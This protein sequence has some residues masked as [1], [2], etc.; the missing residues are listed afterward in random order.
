[1][2]QY[3]DRTINVQK[4]ELL[5]AIQANL[6]A[7][8]VAYEEAVVAYKKE[9]DKQL[10]KQLKELKAGSLSVKLNLVTPINS[11]DEYL[12]LIRMFEM[13]VNDIVELSQQEFNQYIYDETEFSK[14][15]FASNSMY[16][17]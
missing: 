8:Q 5:K 16:V 14:R 13:E 3:S 11:E 6:E 4:S 1:M 7:H 9:A 12:K 10:R 2:R 15:A 17:G